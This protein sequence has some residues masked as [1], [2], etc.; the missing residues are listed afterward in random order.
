MAGEEGKCVGKKC[1]KEAKSDWQSH[2]SCV[3]ILGT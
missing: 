2:T 1:A 3:L